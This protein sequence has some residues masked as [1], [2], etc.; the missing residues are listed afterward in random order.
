MSAYQ[1]ID[2]SVQNRA[3]DA[4]RAAAPSDGGRRRDRP[5]SRGKGRKNARMT[6]RHEA[7]RPSAAPPPGPRDRIVA[8]R[9]AAYAVLAPLAV[10]ALAG[11]VAA[12]LLRHR[13]AGDEPAGARPRHHPRV[14]ARARR[15]RARLRRARRRRAA[16]GDPA[17]LRRRPRR[18]LY[19]GA[20]GADR[21]STRTGCSRCIAIDVAA[22]AGGVA[23]PAARGDRG[24]GRAAR[25]G[26]RDWRSTSLFLVALPPLGRR[27]DGAVGAAYLA[28]AFDYGLR[29]G[30]R[31]LLA[32]AVAGRARLRRRRRRRRRCGAR[33]R[34]PMSRCCSAPVVCCRSMAR[35]S[36]TALPRRAEGAQRPRPAQRR[37]LAMIEPRAARAAQH[38]DRHGRAARPHAA[39]ADAAR[40]ARHH[41]AR[42]AA[43]LGLINDAARAARSSRRGRRRK[44]RA[45]CCARCWAARSRL[46][47]PQAEAQGTS[48]LALMHR[49]APA[50]C[51]P[52]H[53]A[54][55]APAADQ[56]ARQRD[57][58]HAARPH[59]AGRDAGRARRRAGAAAP[60]GA[61]RGACGRAAAASAIAGLFAAGDDV[62][63]GSATAGLGLAIAAAARRPNGRHDLARARAGA[64]TFIGR[65]ALC[66]R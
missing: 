43:L 42:G 62:P 55:A 57:Q 58:A 17:H 63:I 27:G 34:S 21:A 12:A 7:A 61:R 33:C 40:H 11:P 3:R 18:S 22:R 35:R 19:V 48:T 30:A 13:R 47:R 26:A 32:A 44:T 9:L 38:A 52:R 14:L 46:L 24:P 65:A 28:L 39:R 10:A 1:S 2:F 16:A 60:R 49:S 6:L 29:F 54:A 5:E 15:D 51:L 23:R 36:S 31:M 53:A 37:L 64:D 4:R 8:A 20:P 41:A 50:A 25:R 59:R 56:P 66:L 45:S